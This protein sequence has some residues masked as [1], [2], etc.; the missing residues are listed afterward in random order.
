MNRERDDPNWNWRGIWQ[1]LF[2]DQHTGK[3]ER[4]RGRPRERKKARRKNEELREVKYIHIE[5]EY[6][7]KNYKQYIETSSGVQKFKNHERFEKAAKLDTQDPFR[8]IRFFDAFF[9]M[10]FPW[11]FLWLGGKIWSMFP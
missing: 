5:N 9:S 7:K 8:L 10:G 6:S 2:N 1:H 4:E 11:V 3:R